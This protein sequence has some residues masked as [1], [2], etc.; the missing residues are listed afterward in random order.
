MK[1][2]VTFDRHHNHVINGKK[3]DEH[4][5][6]VINHE[7]EKDGHKIAIRYF[8]LDF[9]FSYS[10]KNFDKRIEKYFLRGFVELD[11]QYDQ[12]KEI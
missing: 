9:S 5:I 12:Q 1:T 3:F 11:H 8:G 6:A 7:D 2:Y 10:E 4:C